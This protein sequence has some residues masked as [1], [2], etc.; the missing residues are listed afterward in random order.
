MIHFEARRLKPFDI[1]IGMF[2]HTSTTLNQLVSRCIAYD[3]FCDKSAAYLVVK[4]LWRS[5]R[6]AFLLLM[7]I[8]SAAGY[9]IRWASSE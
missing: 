5:S 1:R 3:R 9:D 2:G 4:T 8:S 6:A 7:A